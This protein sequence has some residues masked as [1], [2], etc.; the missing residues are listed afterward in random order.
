MTMYQLPGPK[1]SFNQVPVPP[2]AS[3]CSPQ[4][5]KVCDHLYEAEPA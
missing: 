4:T 5:A 3:T 2:A 1:P